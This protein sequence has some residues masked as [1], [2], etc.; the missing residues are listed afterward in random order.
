MDAA[1]NVKPKRR[2]RNI[3]KWTAVALAA[4]TV[5][6]F[7][8]LPPIIKKVLLSE[9]SKALHRPVSIQ[10]IKVNPIELTVEIDGVEVKDREG[11][12]VFASFDQLFVDLQIA[13]IYKRGVILREFRLRRPYVNIIRNTD[14]TYNFSD[15]LEDKNPKPKSKP[16]GF[17]VNNIQIT[18]ARADFTDGPKNTAHHVEDVDLLVPFVS[19]LG[20]YTDTFVQPSLTGRLNG[21][22]F[23]FK[24]AT[25]PFADSLDTSLNIKLTSVDIPY[26]LAYSPV[27]MNFR[28]PTGHIDAK[29]EVHY[30]QYKKGVKPTLIVSADVGLDNFELQ[31]TQAERLVYLPK[32]TVGIRS[33]E[34]LSRKVSLTGVTLDSPSVVV[35]RDRKGKLNLLAV[36]PE[37]EKA[38]KNEGGDR[39]GA[40]AKPETKAAPENALSL[41]VDELR[42]NGG[43]ISLTD[44]E[45]GKGFKA[46]LAPVEVSVKGFT[47]EKGRA[48]SVD[49]A[50]KTDAGEEVGLKADVILDPIFA[51]G[52]VMVS[53]VPLKRYAPYYREMLLFDILDGR[54]GLKTGFVYSKTDTGPEERLSGLEVTLTKLSLKKRDEPAPFL[55]VPTLSVKDASIDLNKKKLVVGRIATRNGFI[56][57]TRAKDGILSIARLVNSPQ[58]APSP[59][60]AKPVKKE[61]DWDVLVKKVSA[62]SWTLRMVD[63]WPPRVA[64]LTAEKLDFTGE[65][66]RTAKD[67]MGRINLGFTPNGHGRFTTSGKVGINPLAVDVTF[68][69]RDVEAGSLQ[70]YFEDKVKMVITDG[71]V[72]S[73]GTIKMGYREPDGLH[74]KVAC[75]VSVARF[76]ALDKQ[77]AE[78][79][80]K[81]DNIALDGMEVGYAPNSVA[82]REVSLSNFFSNVVIYPDKTINVT[83]VVERE[84]KPKDTAGQAAKE[85]QSV[86]PVLAPRTTIPPP[87][88]VAKDPKNSWPVRIDRVSLKGCRVN[89]TDRGISPTYKTS[90]TDMEG[91]VT[92]L[93]SEEIKMA[94]VDLKCRFDGAAPVSITGRVNPL[95]ADL[96]VDLKVKLTGMDLSPF[97]PYSGKYIG[98]KIDRGKLSLDLSYLIDKKN[99]DSQ[100]VVFID[101][102]YLGDNVESKDA[103]KLPMKLA[104]ALLRD[105]RG[106]IHLDVPVKGRTDDPKFSKGRII[107]QVLWNVI[108]KAAT[109]PFSLLGSLFGGGADLSFAE[110]GQGGWTLDAKARSTLDSLVKAMDARPALKLTVEGHVDA[111]PDKGWLIKYIFNKKLKAEKLKAMLKDGKPAVPV[112]EVAVAPDEYEKYLKL[113]YKDEKFEKPKNFIGM[114]KGLPAPEMEKLIIAHIEVTDDDLRQLALR[115]AEVAR[116][117]ILASGKVGPERVFAVEPKSLAPEKKEGQ[118]DAKVEFALE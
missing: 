10:K 51:E 32:L 104:L 118:Q 100:N 21:A 70:P 1:E 35:V 22:P 111:G 5:I 116:D 69:L 4:Y 67:S 106:E 91:S 41:E 56:G 98:Y 42:V 11:K 113:A 33:A 72:T 79:L 50:V 80:V 88:A 30:R 62:S 8:L 83:Q 57:F 23:V 17:S 64:T 34:L 78:D 16:L 94:D 107:L 59:K 19:N 29:A 48:A 76:A 71:A 68:N 25:K 36:L 114:T 75:N 3:I 96:Y 55:T 38:G 63:Q 86:T 9:L 39:L 28:I 109:S 47:T 26:Y 27:K 52:T 2:L 77:N 43:N 15:L 49:L 87:D 117:Y 89:L 85:G 95:R 103:T 24:G 74:L 20:Y 110:F 65:D 7:F 73:D 37:S 93:S 84:E 108:V 46:K 18:G 66:I 58:T 81:W 60:P 97:T 53:G 105:R 13:S 40:E 99:L 102:F 44:N 90:L 115:R 82:I 101:Q 45:A 6:G 112:D 12:S 92:G 54:L 14:L 61:K 31:N